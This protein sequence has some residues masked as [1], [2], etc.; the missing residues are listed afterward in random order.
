MSEEEHEETITSIQW[1]PNSTE[2]YT[3]GLDQRINEWKKDGRLMQSWN[4]VPI[5]ITDAALTPDG[6]KF[7]IVG[8]DGPQ[9]TIGPDG[10]YVYSEDMKRL[11]VYDTTTKS[12]DW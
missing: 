9:P 4:E 5:R 12:C 1:K 8:P 7:V 3:V 10:N 11:M 6:T 2:F